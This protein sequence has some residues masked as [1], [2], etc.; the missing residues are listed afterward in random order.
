MSDFAA[1][2]A[3]TQPVRGY[4]LGAC[5][6]STDRSAVFRSVD[7]SLDRPIAVKILRPY[8]GREG[9]VE[10]FF[11]L[12]GSIARLRCPGVAR[13]LDAG[14]ADDNFFLAYEYIAGESLSAR[15]GRR[16]SGR[17]TEK[18]SIRLVAE[19]AGV[20]Q[21]LFEQGHPHGHLHPGNIALGDGWKPTLL[22]IGFAWNLA[23]PDDEAAWA[24]AP[25]HLPPERIRGEL[26][27]DARGDLYSLGA[28]WYEMLAGAPPFRGDT[29]AG[30]LRLHLEA[31]PAPLRD[32]DAKL[33]AA[34]A[35]LALWLLEK[36]RDSRPR[37]P[38]EFL[39]K[40]RA[41]PLVAG[42]AAAD[43]DGDGDATENAASGD[44]GDGDGS[45]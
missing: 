29:P 20:L 10:E 24:A 32:V 35:N 34:T 39:R 11:S 36:E 43:G 44:A 16:Q 40:L 8:P 37:T 18:E 1:A 3:E 41:H 5:L 6:H 14:R 13:G 22:D 31:K 7:R 26:N 2:L 4:E 17:L 25:G 33:S 23:W 12:A 30:T 45:V 42:E 38:R 27:I 28:L 15:L 21:R 9:V 19:L